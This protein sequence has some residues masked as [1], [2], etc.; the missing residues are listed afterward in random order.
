MI[1]AL[2]DAY[3]DDDIRVIVFTGNPAGKNYCAGLKGSPTKVKKTFVPQK[4]SGGVKIKEE[5]T[6]ASARKLFELLSAA[7]II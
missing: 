7:S 6:A 1:D 3:Q 5:D 2:N 4:K